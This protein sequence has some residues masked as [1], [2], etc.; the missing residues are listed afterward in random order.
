MVNVL[1]ADLV[2]CELHVGRFESVPMFMFDTCLLSHRPLS[3]KKKKTFNLQR[4][5]TPII[6]NSG[7]MFEL[8]NSTSTQYTF[9]LFIFF[10]LRISQY[11]IFLCGIQIK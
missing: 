11:F 4:D 8:I 1:L 7:V 5:I 2:N 10:F 6:Q 9:Y 3:T